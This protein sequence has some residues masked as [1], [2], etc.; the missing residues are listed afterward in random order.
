MLKDI[1]L[2][3]VF[4]WVCLVWCLGFFNDINF[5]CGQCSFSFFFSA[6]MQTVHLFKR[7]ESAVWN[8][9]CKAT[10]KV[11]WSV[12]NTEPELSG[13]YSFLGTEAPKKIC[14][15]FTSW[16]VLRPAVLRLL[17]NL[18][19]TLQTGEKFNTIGLNPLKWS[20]NGFMFVT[21]S[22]SVKH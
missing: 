3:V 21:N 15:P 13:G 17:K 20:L 10:R 2:R 14:A 1:A 12:S 4:V 18:R 8:T 19:M 9:V 7:I 22:L 5:S 6:F 16:D 11:N